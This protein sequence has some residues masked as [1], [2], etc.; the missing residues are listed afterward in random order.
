MVNYNTK[1]DGFAALAP[2]KSF[3]KN[4]YG[5][6]DIDGNVWV[7]CSDWY[8]PDYYAKSIAINPKGPKDSYDPY[9]PNLKKHVQ[10]GALICAATSIA[11]VIKQAAAARAKPVVQVIILVLDA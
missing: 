2:V 11:F 7:W 3:P 10:R 6:Y 9:E 8:C 4:G 1:E 5:L